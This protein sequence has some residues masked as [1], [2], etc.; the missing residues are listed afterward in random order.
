MAKETN[1]E[2]K[3]FE[4]VGRRK[5]AVAR[6]RIIPGGTGFT[7][8]DLD[9]KKYFK[10]DRERLSAYAPFKLVAVDKVGVSVKAAGSGLPSQAEAVSLGISRA[11]LKMNAEARPILKAAGLLTRDP[12]MV[13]RKKY[14]LKKARRAPQWAKR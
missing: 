10:T 1:K 11:L 13:E 7:V 6:V 3:Y 12:R 2:S 4:A 8:N 9:Y 14:G 5:T